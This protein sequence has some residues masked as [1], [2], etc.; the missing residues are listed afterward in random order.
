MNRLVF[1]FAGRATIG[2]VGR[3]ESNSQTTAAHNAVEGGCPNIPVLSPTLFSRLIRMMLLIREFLLL[4]PAQGAK[5]W[6]KIAQGL[7]TK[8]ENLVRP[9]KCVSINLSSTVEMLQLLTGEWSYPCRKWFS[10]Q[11]VFF[12]IVFIRHLIEETL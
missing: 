2:R 8:T 1:A 7:P 11:I 10:G 3:F 6:K 9:A 5:S 4:I 12:Q